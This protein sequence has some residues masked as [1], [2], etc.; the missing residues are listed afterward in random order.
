MYSKYDIG[1]GS[2]CFAT[3][4]LGQNRFVFLKK[5]G[6]KR[7]NIFKISDSDTRF[8]FSTMAILDRKMLGVIFHQDLEAKQV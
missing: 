6:K 2:H 1:D 3:G 8:A 4:H 5:K 7:E